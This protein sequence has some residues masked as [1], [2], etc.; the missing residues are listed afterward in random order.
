MDDEILALKRNGTWTL[1]PRP[2]SH[3]VVGCRW[4]FKVKPSPDGSIE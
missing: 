4:I 3:N 2:Q 1:V